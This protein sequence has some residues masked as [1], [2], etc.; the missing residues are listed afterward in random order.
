MLVTRNGAEEA[1]AEPA[2]NGYDPGATPTAVAPEPAVMEVA[3][4]AN[5]PMFPAE[6]EIVPVMLAEVAVMLPPLLTWNVP[7]PALIAI[8]VIVPAEILSALITP[9]VMLL[10]FMLETVTMLAFSVPVLI[11]LALMPNTSTRF[12][13]IEPP[14][15]VMFFATTDPSV[16]TENGLELVGVE[17]PAQ[18]AYPALA[19]R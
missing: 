13:S 19:D 4:I 6:A 17:L 3:L 7:E 2:K 9:L 5:P 15:T 8:E 16:F 10:A 12:A 14:V 1:V 18:M 11:L